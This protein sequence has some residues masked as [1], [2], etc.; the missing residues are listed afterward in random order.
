MVSLDR[1]TLARRAGHGLQQF[2]SGLLPKVLVDGPEVVQ[3]DDVGGN[4][5]VIAVRSEQHL[6]ETVT[7]EQAIRET[8]EGVM[9]RQMTTLYL[10]GPV[11]LHGLRLSAKAENHA[12][13]PQ[14]PPAGIRDA[15]AVLGDPPGGAVRVDKAVLEREGTPSAQRLADDTAHVLA[16]IGKDD[17]LEGPYVLLGEFA[18]RVAGEYLDVI[19]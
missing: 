12:V 3:V 19:H 9:P 17:R 14:R 11:G 6:L 7:D 2:V 18:R 1:S 4:K 15:A 8:G 5:E 16:I 10:G 13:Y